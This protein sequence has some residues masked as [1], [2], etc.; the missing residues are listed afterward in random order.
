MLNS[1]V[2]LDGLFVYILLGMKCLMEFLIY[3]CINVENI[4]QFECMLII[5][6]WGVYVSYLEGCI[7]F[8]CDIV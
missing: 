5:V 4:G 3:F 1:V 2:F 8:K 6:D 7:V